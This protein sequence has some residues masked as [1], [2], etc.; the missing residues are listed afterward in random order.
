MKDLI[1]ASLYFMEEIREA[2]ESSLLDCSLATQRDAETLFVR[3]LSN[4]IVMT[5]ARK[6]E[7]LG[8]EELG[9]QVP[10]EEM[11]IGKIDQMK[12]GDV[13]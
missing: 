3:L 9:I 4:E 2:T 12:A 1:D 10:I 13:V 11:D 5:M 8:E 7:G 6:L